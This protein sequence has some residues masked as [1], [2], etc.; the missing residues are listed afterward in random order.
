MTNQKQ[1]SRSKSGERRLAKAGGFTNPPMNVENRFVSDPNPYTEQE[2]N[3]LLA[4]D[5]VVAR[6]DEV[7]EDEEVTPSVV[8]AL[9]VKTGLVTPPSGGLTTEEVA[10]LAHGL[11]QAIIAA[12]NNPVTT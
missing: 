9:R 6:N 11:T 5:P 4:H 7:S 1:A 2:W 12:R 10:T 8:R 3:P